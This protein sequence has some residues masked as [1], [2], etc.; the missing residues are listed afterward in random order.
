MGIGSFFRTLLGQ[1]VHESPAGERVAVAMLDD[2]VIARTDAYK[3]V[4]GNVYFPPETVNRAY[5]HDSSQTTLCPWKGVAMYYDLAIP[6][7]Q[8]KDVAWYYPSP[9]DAAEGIRDHVAFDRRVTV[10]EMAP[11]R[12]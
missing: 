12:G 6:G 7:R 8:V 3:K 10:R 4:E 1:V 9:S 2:V 5:V 11:T